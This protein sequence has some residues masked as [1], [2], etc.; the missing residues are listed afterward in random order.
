VT[1]VSQTISARGSETLGKWGQ[2]HWG[3]VFPP[4]GGSHITSEHEVWHGS[5]SLWKGNHP[6]SLY[7]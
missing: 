6:P 5:E 7:E 1:I 3:L 2:W 4:V